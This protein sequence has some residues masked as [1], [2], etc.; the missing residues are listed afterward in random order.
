MIAHENKQ[1]VFE[2]FPAREATPIGG[3][4]FSIFID[5]GPIMAAFEARYDA[6]DGDL[7]EA[8]RGGETIEL[9]DALAS[10]GL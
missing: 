2:D 1:T 5:F 6:P 8:R 10:L 3:S 7:I 9:S 4:T